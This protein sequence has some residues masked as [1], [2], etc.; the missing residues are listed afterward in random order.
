MLKK[1][2]FV[3]AALIIAGLLLVACGGGA[4][5][6]VDTGAVDEAV[7]E[8]EARIAELEAQ[9][10]EA[11]GGASEEDVAALQ[12][13]LEDAQAAADEAK[14]EAQAAAEAQCSYNAYRM[15][16]VMDYSDPVNIVNEVFA[17]TSDSNY[18]FWGN[19][20]PDEAA[21]FEELVAQAVASTDAEERVALWQQ[22]E[23]IVVNDT[24]VVIPIYHYDRTNL[25]N[26]DL[27]YTYAPFGAPKV[28]FWSF[29]SGKTTLKVPLAAAVPTLDIQDST[30]TTS[31]FVIYQMIDAP[32][33][34]DEEG[35]IVPHAATGFEVSDDGKVYTIFLR[36][37]AV[38]SDGEPVVAQH[39][40]DG[41]TRLLSPDMA[42]DY[43]FMMFAIE[44]A[45][46]YNA[47]ETET[48]DSVVAV[49][50]YTLQVT[51]KEPL[52]YFESI[53]AFQ[54]MHPV[55]LDIIEKYGED[56]VKPGNFVSNGA[57]IL[58]EHKPGEEVVLTKNESYWDADNVAIETIEL[59]I[60]IEPATSLAAFEAGD[61]DATNAM[62]AG[63]PGE[64]TARLI[65][66]Y[67]DE[68]VRLPR[69][70][71]WYVGLN[72]TAEHTNNLNFRRA[73][74]S[75]VDK[76]V[77][78]DEVIGKPWR[79]DAYGIIPPEIAGYQGKDIGFAYDLEAAQSYLQAYMDE[80]GI[81]D[82]GEI[83]IELW[84]NKSGDNQSILEAVEAMWEANLGIDVRTVNV[85]W[86]TYLETLEECNVI[87]GGGF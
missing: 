63:Y 18:T 23:N 35:N 29:D 77:I 56:W 72:T 48:L 82:P 55:R 67:P 13:E 84:Y 83:V 24:T 71:T 20:Y 37:D 80:A 66:E 59:P 62:D 2:W 9:L 19:T 22:A 34:F 47:G 21:A 58:A 76:R 78:L 79:I 39:F 46:E 52:S 64:E 61:V 65:E 8:A 40:V 7:S 74:S 87:G 10:A 54:T 49:D 4:A 45:A 44:G 6:A 11:E 12:A 28:S 41:I 43:A 33:R 57:Y 15:G 51:L 5:P 53:L 75:A 69:P 86:G 81:E 1:R 70:G 50:D 16:W 38:W 26:T 14:A 42:N 36:E 17:P 31:S 73:L 25:I 3:L 85:E 60:I 27:N 30:D 68:F 32:Y